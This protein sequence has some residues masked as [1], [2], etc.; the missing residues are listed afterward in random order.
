MG[1]ASL[2]RTPTGGEIDYSR[3]EVRMKGRRMGLKSAAAGRKV[4]QKREWN[5]GAREARTN[6]M[7]STGTVGKQ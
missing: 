6:V 5:N 2:G 1:V 3:L 7:E 4:D